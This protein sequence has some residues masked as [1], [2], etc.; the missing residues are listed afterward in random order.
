MKRPV[1]QVNLWRWPSEL[2]P[3]LEH[4]KVVTGA[5]VAVVIVGR[6][7]YRMVHLR[8]TERLSTEE[9]KQ[10]RDYGWMLIDTSAKWC[11]EKMVYGRTIFDL[12]QERKM[13]RIPE[14]VKMIPVK[15]SN[16]KEVGHDEQDNTLYVTYIKSGSYWYTPFPDTMFQEL[17]ATTSIGGFINSRIRGNKA[18]KY[19]R[20]GDISTEL[21]KQSEKPK[22]DVKAVRR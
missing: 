11:G 21:G 9:L 15:S 12:K 8:Q 17:I 3:A 4:V 5:E 1:I 13:E 20:V 18:I 19:G 10:L 22:R 7:E 2:G 14:H 16:V 6:L